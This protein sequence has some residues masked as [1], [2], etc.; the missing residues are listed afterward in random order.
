MIDAHLLNEL[1]EAAPVI[2]VLVIDDPKT[3]RPLGEALVSGGLCVLE[4]TLRTEAA[5]KAISIMSEIKGAYVGAGTVLSDPQASAA[6]QAG[7]KFAVSPGSTP[8]LRQACF[9][10]KLPLLPGAATGSEIMELLEAGYAHQKFF[11]AEAIGGAKALGALASPLPQVTFCPTGGVTPQNAKEYLSLGNVRCV[12]G[13]WVAPKDLIKARDWS[14]IAD[15]AKS[16]A[17]LPR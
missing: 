13:S 17:R 14:G 15:L 2:P 11:P 4:V 3:A 9:D 5:I 16:A 8:A 1:F 6:K 7:A 10:H 12:G